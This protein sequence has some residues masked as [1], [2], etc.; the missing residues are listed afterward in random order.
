MRTKPILIV[1]ALFGGLACAQITLISSTPAGSGLCVSSVASSL[2]PENGYLSFTTTTAYSNV[3]IAA[4]LFGLATGQV[5]AYLSNSVGPGANAFATSAPVTV[6]SAQTNLTLFSGLTLPAGTYYLV[7]TSN[8]ACGNTAIGWSYA[9][10]TPT[11]GPGVTLGAEGDASPFIGSPNASNPV[12]TTFVTNPTLSLSV[13]VTAASA[14]VPPIGTPIPT[15]LMLG[16]AGL[17]AL[18]IYQL[19]RRKQWGNA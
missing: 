14:P 3:T 4:N 13:Q 7:L 10:G 17:A 15:S 12:A 5:T 6:P 9:T 16:A 11:V 2:S 8:M 19:R 18:G 1:A